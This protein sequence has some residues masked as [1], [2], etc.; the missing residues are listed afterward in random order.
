MQDRRK[1]RRGALTEN[2]K[3]KIIQGLQKKQS[4]LEIAKMLGRDHRTIKKYAT[5]PQSCNGRADKGKIREKSGVSRRV[6]SLIKREVHRN[7][8]QTSKQVFE[9]VGLFNVPKSTRCSILQRIAK[10]KKPLV[11]P[12]LKQ[13]HREKRLEWAKTYLK[14]NFEFVLFTDECRATLDGPDGWRRGWCDTKALCPQRI[15]RQQG[16][17]GVMFWA[18]I[19]HDELVGPFRV[20]DGVKMTATTYIA[21]LREHWLPWYKKKSLAFRNKMVFMQDNAPSMLRI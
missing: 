21:F 17:G 9:A 20:K 8:L 2:E 4:T 14:Q 10:C 5:N 1:G 7:P 15:R 13:V 3:A 12:P 11:R 16:G 19:I 6:I 18:A